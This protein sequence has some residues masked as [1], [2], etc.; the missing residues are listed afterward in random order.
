MDK[1]GDFVVNA[2][3]K[4]GNFDH[5]TT[6]SIESPFQMGTNRQYMGKL[7]YYTGFSVHITF[8]ST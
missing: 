1:I 6:I 4:D 8:K 7:P 3:M 5:Y 2:H